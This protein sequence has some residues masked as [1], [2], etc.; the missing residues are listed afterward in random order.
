MT[1]IGIA[2]R[3]AEWKYALL[4]HLYCYTNFSDYVAIKEPIEVVVIKNDGSEM[5]RKAAQD[6]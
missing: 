1:K 6:T 4:A 3:N 5:L 2:C